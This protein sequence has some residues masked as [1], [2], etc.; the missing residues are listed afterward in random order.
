MEGAQFAKKQSCPREQSGDGCHPRPNADLDSLGCYL[1]PHMRVELS[2]CHFNN[3]GY[4]EFTADDCFQQ[5]KKFRQKQVF[6]PSRL[7]GG[8]SATS[9]ENV[10]FFS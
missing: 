4:D 6:F 9:K 1:T 5:T 8:E 7:P 3:D 10:L 2:S